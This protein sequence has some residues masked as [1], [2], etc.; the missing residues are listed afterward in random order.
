M[1]WNVRQIQH[2]PM[3]DGKPRAQVKSFVECTKERICFIDMVKIIFKNNF[4]L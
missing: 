2:D 3:Y 4:V 1:K